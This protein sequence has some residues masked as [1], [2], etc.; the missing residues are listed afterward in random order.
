MGGPIWNYATGTL[1]SWTWC[2]AGSCYRTQLWGSAHP[3][4]LKN[5]Q[6][7]GEL[8]QSRIKNNPPFRQTMINS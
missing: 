8:Q 7:K 6:N 4:N 3:C 1:T 2:Q 5:N